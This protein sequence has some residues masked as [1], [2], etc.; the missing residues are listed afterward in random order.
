[1]IR[2]PTQQACEAC[3]RRKIKCSGAPPCNGCLAAN[4]PCNFANAGTKRGGNRARATVLN[5]LRGGRDDAEIGS[6]G[7]AR[8]VRMGNEDERAGQLFTGEGLED[9]DSGVVETCVSA[10]LQRIH[11]VVP[12]LTEEILRSE[13]EEAKT[14]VSSRQFVSSFCAYVITFGKVLDVDEHDV[15]AATTPPIQTTNAHANT[16]YG[17]RLL[18]AALRIQYPERIAEPTLRD[19]FISFFLYGALAGLGDYRMGWFYLREATT[20]FEMLRVNDGKRGRMGM[21]WWGEEIY[22]RTFWVLVV[23]ERAH[24][25][26]RNRPITLQITPSSPPLNSLS[27]I[28]AGLS[29]LTQL[30]RPFDSVFF[31]VWNASQQ[32]CS[33]DWLLGLERDIRTALPPFLTG[34]L[35]NE[36]VAN[37]RVSQLW[38]RIKLWELF[39]RF[40]FLSSDSVY[41]CLTFRYPIVVASELMVLAMKLPIGSLQTHGVGMTEKIFDISCALA[42]ILPF[43]PSA[44]THPPSLSHSTSNPLST[45]TPTDYLTSTATLLAKLPSGPEKFLPLLLAKLKELRPELVTRLC[46]ACQCPVPVMQGPMSPDTRGWYEEEVGGSL[47]RD[48]R[49]GVL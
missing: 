15:Q 23:S 46:E 14:E 37:L 24:A 9:V 16:T 28:D 47:Q 30:F 33:K 38:L 49:G 25:I 39:P 4:L 2:K 19:V 44:H 32:H 40:G 42:D 21:G 13:I 26:R 27:P 18:Y 7:V 35:S 29:H 3:R 43:I 17:R 34:T 5:E 48:L 45:L 6:S 22:G 12:F 10:Y 31:A 1:M 11:P 41:E 36:Q 8:D 20:L